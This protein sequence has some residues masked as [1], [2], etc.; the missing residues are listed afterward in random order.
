[1]LVTLNLNTK[2]TFRYTIVYAIIDNNYSYYRSNVYQKMVITV[3]ITNTKSSASSSKNGRF[4]LQALNTN[5]LLVSLS[6]SE[7]SRKMTWLT[8]SYI[9]PSPLLLSSALT[10]AP[11]VCE[12]AELL[13]LPAQL[14]VVALLVTSPSLGCSMWW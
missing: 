12:P 7:V 6:Q 14:D 10:T 2:V 9:Y 11:Y 8:L 4:G 1:M 3:K 5:S 13:R